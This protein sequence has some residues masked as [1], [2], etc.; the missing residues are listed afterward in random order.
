MAMDSYMKGVTGSPGKQVAPV[1]PAEGGQKVSASK[2][3]IQKVSASES[4]VKKAAA[5]TAAKNASAPGS[6]VKKAS[7]K[8]SSIKKTSVPKSSA[9][10]AF[11]SGNSILRANKKQAVNVQKAARVKPAGL[12]NVPETEEEDMEVLFNMEKEPAMSTIDSAISKM[13]AEMAKTRC[14]YAYD[15]DTKRITIKV[16]DDETDELIREVPPE[17][18]LEVLKK[19]WEMAGI[20]IDEKF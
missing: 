11:V 12:Q 5:G 14:A 1:K 3:S 6:S 20:M 2:D 15:E 13:N 10:K 17:K 7:A 16:Y 18:S 8:K 9:K 4:A 19:V